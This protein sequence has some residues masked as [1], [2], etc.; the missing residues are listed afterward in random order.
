MSRFK[1]IGYA[2]AGWGYQ[3]FLINEGFS[4]LEVARLSL[5]F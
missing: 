4:S 2:C 1:D 3:V 5:M